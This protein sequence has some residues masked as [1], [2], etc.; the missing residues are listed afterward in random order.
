M[1]CDGNVLSPLHLNGNDVFRRLLESLLVS[2]QLIQL[3]NDYLFL[4]IVE[5]RVVA[6]LEGPEE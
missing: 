2:L 5:P 1:D 4:A 3:G 6:I